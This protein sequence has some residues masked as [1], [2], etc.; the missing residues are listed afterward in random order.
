MSRKKRKTKK[1]SKKPERFFSFSWT[2]LLALIM[3]VIITALG[4]HLATCFAERTQQ[5]KEFRESVVALRLSDDKMRQDLDALT[6]VFSDFVEYLRLGKLSIP[7]I[8][9]WNDRM[10]S[11]A[12]IT[13]ADCTAAEEKFFRYRNSLVTLPRNFLL[14]KPPWNE[15]KDEAR[16]ERCGGFLLEVSQGLYSPNPAQ[17]VNDIEYRRRYVEAQQPYVLNYKTQIEKYLRFQRVRDSNNEKLLA[18]IEDRNGTVTKN[19]WDCLRL[20]FRRD[21]T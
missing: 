18:I 10:K 12:Q 19:L 6:Q 11:M 9:K 16:R 17:L 2:K 13:S 8:E 3:S 5:V 4:W 7:E 14:P 21:S 15:A 20:V 1:G